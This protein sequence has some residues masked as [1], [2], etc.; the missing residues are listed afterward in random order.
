MDGGSQYDDFAADYEWVFSDPALTGERHLDG[1]SPALAGLAP[2]AAILDASCG[3]GRLALALARRQLRVVGTDASQGM[4]ARART[5]A[6]EQGLPVPFDVCSWEDLPRRFGQ[7]FGLVV[8]CGNAI[9]HCHDRD[10]MLR[11]LAGMRAVMRA[12]GRLVL[13]TRNWEKLLAERVRFT[14]FGL[15]SRAGAQCIPVYAWTFP[16]RCGDPVVV[17]VVLVFEHGGEVSLRV[18][19][20]TYYPFR[21]KELLERLAAAGFTDLETDYAPEREVYRV[22]ASRL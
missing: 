17:E 2:G 9:G 20:I 12:G 5:H 16:P 8:C 3:T 19:P 15:R 10:E 22:W 18:Y 14:H 7:E 13:D 6:A 1:L 21:V 11:S 4:I